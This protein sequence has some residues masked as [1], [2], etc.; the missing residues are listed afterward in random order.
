MFLT[1][2][3]FAD[4]SN[5]FRLLQCPDLKTEVYKVERYHKDV[6]ALVSS[7]M[8]IY[9]SPFSCKNYRV[10]GENFETAFRDSY[11]KMEE[12]KTFLL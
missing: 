1:T 11:V 6:I 12:K 5:L 3:A 7:E 4:E 9:S 10:I 2:V 8:R